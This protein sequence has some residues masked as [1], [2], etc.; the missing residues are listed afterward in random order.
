MLHHYQSVRAPRQI[1]KLNE[2]YGKSQ[3]TTKPLSGFTAINLFVVFAVHRLIASL[4]H[5][6]A[7]NMI[8]EHLRVLSAF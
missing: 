7:C 3:V 4:T 2:F 6:E 1:K 5:S 8:A